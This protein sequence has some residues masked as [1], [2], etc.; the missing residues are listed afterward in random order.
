MSRPV[1]AGLDGSRASLA[2]ADWAAR[3]ALRRGRQ[4]RLVHAWEGL[5]EEPTRTSLTEPRGPWVGARHV[6][7]DTAVS[8]GERYPQLSIAPVQVRMR[9][10]PALLAE[11]ENA[12][13]LVIGSQGLG[14]V[15][16]FLSGSVALA[17]VARVERPVVLVRAGDSAPNEHLP[18]SRGKQSDRTPY[19]DVAVGVD[20]DAPCDAVLEFAFHAAELRGAPLRVVQAWH[21]PYIRG[22]PDAQERAQVKAEA[23][24]RLEVLLAPWREKFPTVFV[25]ESPYEGRPAHVLVKAAA[26]AGL[27][28]VGRRRRRP[29]ALPHTGPVAHALI[30]HVMCPVALVPHD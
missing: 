24:R 6:L 7:R 29:A 18:D 28:V 30:H 11:A 13:F 2:A 10:G 16:G 27:L 4:L 14:G 9:P 23:E 25:R 22:L 19:R 12:E 3:E 1:V 17:A 20:V 26:G 21:V 8:L 5:P 15:G